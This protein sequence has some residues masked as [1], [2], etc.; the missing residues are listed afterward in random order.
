ML[1][2]WNW[3]LK[4]TAIAAITAGGMLLGGPVTAMA[5]PDDTTESVEETQDTSAQE[6][7]TT[8]AATATDEGGSDTSDEAG[9][10]QQ[11]TEAASEETDESADEPQESESAN[12]TTDEAAGDQQESE[13]ATEQSDE[14]E[15]GG[16][17]NE[18]TADGQE[19]QDKVLASVQPADEQTA[20]KPV[21]AD[22]LETTKYPLDFAADPT[23]RSGDKWSWDRDT[24]TL[25]LNGF[26]LD[27]LE[28][29]NDFK[30]AI[31]FPEDAETVTIVHSG[32]S[33]IQY[34]G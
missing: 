30:A 1:K 18:A 11:E 14:A 17:V 16:E 5:A 24:A 22:A 29:D 27:L 21:A 26:Y 31:T 9:D 19:S 4:A 23:S 2:K 6:E 8:E 20:E 33:L 12:D 3:R 15:S 10:D 34:T 28:Y 13:A 32:T 7:D 25:T